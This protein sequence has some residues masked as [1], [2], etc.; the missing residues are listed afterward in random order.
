MSQI[1]LDELYSCTPE[2][3]IVVAENKADRS[4]VHID[5]T[6]SGLA[7][8]CVC[9][10]CGRDMVA[11][12]GRVR[13]HV[14]AHCAH[15]AE[16]CR[17]GE[18][19]LHKFAKELLSS[20]L[21]LKLPAFTMTDEHGSLEVTKEIDFTFDE[22][23][24][25]K[26]TGEVI[27]DVICR[28][29]D[30]VLHVEFLVTHAC[31]RAKLAKLKAMQVSVIEIDL[32]AFRGELLTSLEDAILFRAPRKWLLNPR[33]SEKGAAKLAGRK[34]EVQEKKN[35][36]IKNETRRL[37]DIFGHLPDPARLYIGEWERKAT[38]CG[39]ADLIGS[40]TCE[41][42]CF[43]V[44]DAEWRAF[45]LL[46]P[47][48]YSVFDFD[49]QVSEVF[50][51]ICH[52]RWVRKIFSNL[53]PEMVLG[54]RSLQPKFLTP[55]EAV[56]RFLEEMV[57]AGWLIIAGNSY[58]VSPLLRSRIG[59]SDH[60]W[61]NIR[62]EQLFDLIDRLLQEIP[63]EEKVGFYFTSWFERVAA[64]NN[65]SPEKFL[66]VDKSVWDDFIRA[67][68]PLERTL[69]GDTRYPYYGTFG[70]PV[71]RQ[72]ERRCRNGGEGWARAQSLRRFAF[73]SFGAEGVRWAIGPSH[74]L[75]DISPV[76]AACVS[77]DG[78]RSARALLQAKMDAR[79][80]DECGLSED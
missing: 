23:V 27:P 4:R 46:L 9:P 10:G 7:C 13:A 40:G 45:I 59:A 33:M 69:Q 75:G 1:T 68:H 22:A 44:R 8:E 2:G 16:D 67:F 72:I 78:E 73:D 39:L 47:V 50:Q 64:G 51:A 53:R 18:S 5:D 74:D 30:R 17:P 34:I 56:E 66:K 63:A 36:E 14:F 58:K 25:E 12:K 26:R 48:E 3:F 79:S 54:I 11:R 76:E 57:A 52:R 41:K 60:G 32:S 70:L 37:A 21:R 42:S 20:R 24:L 80:S 6:V 55:R 61:P 15:Q 71:E 77:P 31:D 35:E 19:A 28:R 29:A 62:R 49:G 43:T 65:T 38:A